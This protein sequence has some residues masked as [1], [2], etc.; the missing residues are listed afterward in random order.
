METL[1]NQRRRANY[2]QTNNSK[3]ANI[4]YLVVPFHLLEQ[5]THKLFPKEVGVWSKYI[6]SH[7]KIG[8]VGDREHATFLNMWL[9]KF[10]F[11][12]QL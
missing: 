11:V 4:S 5:T 1:K 9:D 6:A 8:S 7:M 10:V 2:P 12:D 3:N